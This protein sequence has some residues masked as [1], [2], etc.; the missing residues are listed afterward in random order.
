ML[1]LLQAATLFVVRHSK[2]SGGV[3][4]VLVSGQEQHY[5]HHLTWDTNNT[6]CVQ[7]QLQQRLPLLTSK[8]R[9]KAV[10]IYG[11][12][13]APNANMRILPP[14]SR[15]S[16][17]LHMETAFEQRKIVLTLE[18]NEED[19]HIAK[20][21]LTSGAVEDQLQRAILYSAACLQS[22]NE[23]FCKLSSEVLDS[24]DGLEQ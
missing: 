20:V 3:H 6:T 18:E 16:L 22:N 14:D 10:Q 19:A 4:A 8:L 5:H 12:V 13:E 7:H 9:A 24:I 1:P 11:K 15:V 17:L 23:E 21:A 2:H